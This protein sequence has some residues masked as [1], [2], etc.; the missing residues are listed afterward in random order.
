MAIVVFEDALIEQAG[1]EWDSRE[2]YT[3]KFCELAAL[4]S[5]EG[6]AKLAARIKRS[7]ST[8]ENYRNAYKLYYY[9]NKEIE[10]SET[11]TMWDDLYPSI[12]QVMARQA[13][14]HNLS[15]NVVLEHLRHAKEC[16]LSVDAFAAHV[17][18]V[19][20]KIPEWQRRFIR[21]KD[22]ILKLMND[23]MPELS[24]KKQEKLR[25]LFRDFVAGL[26]ELS[27]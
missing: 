15:P 19:E 7:V 23:Y 25:Q 2:A 14:K 11:S 18:S 24:P 21:I 16:G 17:E 22:G 27:E 8:V 4:V 10:T 9:L 6:T 12:W 3:R 20:N 1:Q 5:G 26:E 13:K